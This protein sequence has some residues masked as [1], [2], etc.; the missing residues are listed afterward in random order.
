HT[1]PQNNV[2]VSSRKMQ[3]FHGQMNVLA[4][5][6]ERFK[7]SNFTVVFLGTNKERTQRLSSVLADHENEAAMTDSKTASVQ[8]Q[9]SIME[10]ELQSRFELALMKLHVIT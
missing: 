6:I 2:N 5:E 4:G 3:S 9:V 1:S 8:G 7:K 10:G